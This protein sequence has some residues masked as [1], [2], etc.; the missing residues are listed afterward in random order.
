MG[1]RNYGLGSRNMARAGYLALIAARERGDVSHSTVDTNTQRWTQFVRYI[2]DQGVRRMEHIRAEHVRSYATWLREAGKSPKTQ[3]NAISA[4][5]SIMRTAAGNR[6]HSVRP[7]ADAGCDRATEV[8]TL[9]PVMTD[10]TTW[11]KAHDALRAA[12]G[13]RVAAV[14]GLAR[15]LGLRA[16]EASLGSPRTWVRQLERGETIRIEQGTKGGRPR[17]LVITRVSQRNAIECAALIQGRDRSMIPREQTWK[18]W[19]QGELRNIAQTLGPL[20][21]ETRPI[22]SLRAAYA[23]ERYMDLTG[24]RPVA[25]GGPRLEREVDREARLT[26]STEL[27]HNRLNVAVAYIGGTR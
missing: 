10:R 16:K 8:R 7:V 9:Y 15:E 12:H 24:Q 22:H 5:N 26:I 21:G 3:Q 17:E 19:R 20:T 25:F 14:A 1:T 2:H 23:T 27:G 11:S 18:S 13:E 6:W 4:V